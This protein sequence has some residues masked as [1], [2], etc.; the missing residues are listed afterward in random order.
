MFVV[1][2]G[3]S[4]HVQQLP[5]SNT[6]SPTAPTAPTAPTTTTTKRVVIYFALLNVR[7]GQ[8]LVWEASVKK[9]RAHRKEATDLDAAH[10]STIGKLPLKTKKRSNIHAYT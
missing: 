10:L 7:I 1:D 9:Q 3:P 2:D 6:S 4:T 8:K 5:N